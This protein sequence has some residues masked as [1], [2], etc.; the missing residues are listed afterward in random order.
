MQSKF[1]KSISYF[2]NTFLFLKDLVE[3]V[4]HK[5]ME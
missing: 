5:F 3:A 1:F 4:K 2:I